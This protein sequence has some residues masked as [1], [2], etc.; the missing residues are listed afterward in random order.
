MDNED[1]RL[2]HTEQSAPRA[3]KDGPDAER[4]VVGSPLLGGGPQNSK[5][6]QIKNEISFS[7]RTLNE[8]MSKEKNRKAS[9]ALY[10]QYKERAS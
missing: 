1:L 4:L 6:K 5:V 2:I 8:L 10:Q 7:P 9:D 3:A